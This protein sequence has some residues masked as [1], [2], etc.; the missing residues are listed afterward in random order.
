MSHNTVKTLKLMEW[1][2]KIMCPS[3]GIVLDPYC[4]SGTTCMAA[5]TQRAHYVGIERDPIYHEIALKRVAHIRE[6]KGSVISAQDTCAAFLD[7]E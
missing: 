6:T 5:I 1:L 2:V 3:G 7:L 4:G